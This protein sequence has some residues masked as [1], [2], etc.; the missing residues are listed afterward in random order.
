MPISTSGGSSWRSSASWPSARPARIRWSPRTVSSASKRTFASPR[1]CPPTCSPAARRSPCARSSACASPPTP[2]CPGWSSAPST[3]TSARNKSS[4]PSPTG[5][6]TTSASSRPIFPRI[7]RG[8]GNPRASS[9][10]PRT[11]YLEPLI[12]V[13]LVPLLLLHRGQVLGRRIE[14]AVRSLR[15][16]VQQCQ[17]HRLR[18]AGSIAAD[19]EI[20]PALQPGIELRAVLCHPVLHVDLLF[21][22]PRKCEV[23]PRQRPSLLH[24]GEL[25]L[26]QKVVRMVLVAKEK[27]VIAGRANRLPLFQKRPERRHSRPRPDHDDWSR[28]V[29][30]QLEVLVVREK[31][32]QHRAYLRT[33]AQLPTGDALPVAAMGVVA[34]HAHAGLGDAGMQGLARSEE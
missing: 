5:D 3:K 24:R 33:L 6:P 9:F 34:H 13:A 27:P 31:D 4:R 11:Y 28:G 15:D 26:I 2:N 20:G 22:V 30:R 32:R 14:R 1:S 8:S 25:L 7:K 17:L 12:D 23:Q 29:L 21:L 10:E 18:H 16:R 19:I